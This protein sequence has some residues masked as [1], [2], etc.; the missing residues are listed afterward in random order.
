MFTRLVLDRWR[1]PGG[2]V[3]LLAVKR[4]S[5]R[6]QSLDDAPQSPKMILTGSERACPDH[7]VQPAAPPGNFGG[8]GF[9]GRRRQ[10]RSPPG[11][12]AGGYVG[13]A[14]VAKALKLN[15]QAAAVTTL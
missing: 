15:R 13:W 10:L 12:Q 4:S 2:V 11:R 3:D 14:A 8:N 6:R 5:P 1:R 9:L 7:Q